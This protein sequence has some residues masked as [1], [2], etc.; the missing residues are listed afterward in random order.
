M[1]QCLSQILIEVRVDVFLYYIRLPPA[2]QYYCPIDLLSRYPAISLNENSGRKL[3]SIHCSVPFIILNSMFLWESPLKLS[4][5][6][7]GMKLANS[8]NFASFHPS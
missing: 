6:S 3:R 1:A 2:Q 5:K 7:F 8:V 4:R